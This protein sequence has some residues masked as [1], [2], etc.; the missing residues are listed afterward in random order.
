MCFDLCRLPDLSTWPCCK[1]PGIGGP[2][3]EFERVCDDCEDGESCGGCDRF[4][5]EENGVTYCRRWCA[6]AYRNP[7]IGKGKELI[8]KIVNIANFTTNGSRGAFM[9]FNENA[10]EPIIKFDDIA[11][12]DQY[13]QKVDEVNE[14]FL[15]TPILF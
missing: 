15:G 11:S 7:G 1:P 12:V 14:E 4:C 5:F 13:N 2:F 8:K 3:E 6:N 10:N 9:T